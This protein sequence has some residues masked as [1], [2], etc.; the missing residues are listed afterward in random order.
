MN[1]LHLELRAINVVFKVYLAVDYQEKQFKL[2]RLVAHDVTP[3]PTVPEGSTISC[4]SPTLEPAT[5]ALIVIAIVFG[6]ALS[7]ILLYC[8]T[9]RSRASPSAE[10]QTRVNNE[11]P[12]RP[13]RDGELPNQ[14]EGNTDIGPVNRRL[15]DQLPEM[16]G[17]LPT[18]LHGRPR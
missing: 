4:S 5:I 13:R 9:K 17:R 7:G 15:Q 12:D 14:H 16:G 3:D 8:L 10:S 2:S 18:E 1:P 11:R 6:L